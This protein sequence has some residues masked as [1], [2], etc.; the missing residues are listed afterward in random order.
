RVGESLSTIVGA[1]NKTVDGIT[2]I[3]EQTESQA[4]AAGQV[5]TAIKSV[6][7]A[8]ESGAVSAEELAASAEELGAQAQS[9]KDLVDNFNR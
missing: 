7:E 4:A 1:V 6:S 9:L 5:Q 2:Q 8:V 3:A